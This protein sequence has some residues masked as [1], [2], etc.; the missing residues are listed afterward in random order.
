MELPQSV[1][2]LSKN[3]SRKLRR[4]IHEIL[5]GIGAS[6][7]FPVWVQYTTPARRKVKNF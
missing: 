2:R 3:V 4:L 5:H 7:S 1:M 6:H